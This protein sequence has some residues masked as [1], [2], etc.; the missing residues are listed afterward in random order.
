MMNS[1][2]IIEVIKQDLLN[3]GVVD[4]LALSD[5]TT[6]YGGNNTDGLTWEGKS[7]NS[8]VLISN[9]GVSPGFMSTYGL[10]ILEGR[11]FVITDSIT[12]KK[13][14]ILIT[15][16]LEKLMGKGNAVGKTYALGW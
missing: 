16:S 9:R 7:A 2:K 1:I 14:N 11:D 13:Q 4:N 15:Q 12:S 3:S 5:Y 8:K 10:K 6:L